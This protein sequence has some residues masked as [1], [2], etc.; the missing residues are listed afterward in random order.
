MK[1]ADLAFGAVFEFKKGSLAWRKA[2]G[3]QIKAGETTCLT[4]DRYG[5]RED[6][7]PDAE[8]IPVE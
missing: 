2:P 4:A 1:F 6:I 7:S 8:V 3:K 5:G